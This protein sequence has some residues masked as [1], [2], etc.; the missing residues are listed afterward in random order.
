MK[1]FLRKTLNEL[2]NPPLW[3]KTLNFITTIVLVVASFF[4]LAYQ[5]ANA[6]ISAILYGVFGLSALSLAYTFYLIVVTARNLKKNVVSLLERNEFADRLLTNYDYRMV[7]LTIVSFAISVIFGVFNGYMGVKN[8]SV[9]YGTLAVY[10]ISLAFIRGSVLVYHKKSTSKSKEENELKLQLSNAKV[11]RNSGIIM[12]VLNITLSSAVVQMTVSGAHFSY[13]GRTIFAYAAYAFF[14]ISMAIV[15][16]F[17]AHKNSDLTIRAITD[18]NLTAAAVS[19]LAL[20]TAMLATFSAG[21]VNI[22]M[23]NACTGTVVCLITIGL[24]VYM[25]VS[26]H[27]KIKTLNKEIYCNEQ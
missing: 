16:L 12:L 4:L 13:V 1:T 3:G 26:A 6:V 27:K 5:D 2:K 15:N 18:I 20:Q 22:P 7:V 11:Y 21:N 19:I 25:I 24:G 14:K 8:R 10:Y 23:A 9:W 17:R